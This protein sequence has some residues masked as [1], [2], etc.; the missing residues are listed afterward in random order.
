MDISR[1]TQSDMY[2]DNNFI[3][4]SSV[5]INPLRWRP[6]ISFNDYMYEIHTDGLFT[7]DHFDIAIINEVKLKHIEELKN[8]TKAQLLHSLK[9]LSMKHCDQIE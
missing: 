5:E 9:S 6:E 8:M 3:N 4:E 1:T 7:I 2:D